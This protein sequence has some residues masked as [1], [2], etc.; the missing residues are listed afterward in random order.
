MIQS[1]HNE[2]SEV[3]RSCP[4]CG[5]AIIEVIPRLPGRPKRWCSTK[6][7]RAASEERRAAAAGAI[8]IEYRSLDVPLEDHVKAVL[9]SP[10]ACRR[11]VRDLR[12]RHDAGDLDD[13]R[14]SPVA[15]ELQRTRR[16]IHPTLRWGAH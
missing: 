15:E 10:A 5:T 11:I 16:H 13:A 2:Q 6:C 4:R 1:D 14:W 12:E 3:R 9:T 7:R 8:A